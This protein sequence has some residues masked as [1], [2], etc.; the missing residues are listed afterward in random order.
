MTFQEIAAEVQTIRAELMNDPDK[1]FKSFKS[2]WIELSPEERKQLAP[3]L[4]DYCQL[5]LTTT[6]PQPSTTEAH[7]ACFSAVLNFINGHYTGQ[8]W[9]GH[10]DIDETKS[11]IELAAV[12]KLLYDLRYIDNTLAEISQ[13]FGYVFNVK[14]STL[15]SYFT[16]SERL[17]NA[18]I[19]FSLKVGD[20]N[21]VRGK[22]S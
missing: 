21:L 9:F 5:K 12:I 1:G 16:Q 19:E 17:Q 13:V 20:S 7:R 3:G 10:L 11:A 15:D 2:K 6:N 22:F 14:A 8:P 4:V 18:A